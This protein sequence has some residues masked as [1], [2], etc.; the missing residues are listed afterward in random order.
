MIRKP[1]C[2]AIIGS[3][4]Y[5]CYE[6][7]RN[8]I[9]AWEAKHQKMPTILTG[10]ALGVER[11][12]QKFAL[13]E[14]RKLTLFSNKDLSKRDDILL[15]RADVAM[16]FSSGSSPTTRITV[17]KLKKSNIPVYEY[18]VGKSAKQQ[19]PI[20]SFFVQKTKT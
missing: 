16:S 7:V 17:R 5:S 2:L 20:T 14:K 18:M 13:A 12:A 1:T 6:V 10:D 9:L 3:Y 11:L 15:S 19:K 4:D 8:H